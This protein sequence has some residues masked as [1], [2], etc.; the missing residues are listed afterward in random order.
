M[1]RHFYL[2][3][4]ILFLTV[5]C[6]KQQQPDKIKPTR[7]TTEAV[8]HFSQTTDPNYCS[9]DSI[10]PTD[11]GIGEIYLAK[12]GIAF[13]NE[14][15]MG[16]ENTTIIV[17][18]YSITDS[19][20]IC[21]F[22]RYYTYYDCTDCEEQKPVDPNSGKFVQIKPHSVEL[23]KLNCTDYDYCVPQSPQTS[24][25]VF[26]KSDEADT[27]KFTEFISKINS[28]QAL[29]TQDTSQTELDEE[30][31]A[32]NNL[33]F[34]KATTLLNVRNGAGTNYELLFTLSNGSE[35]EFISEDNEWF[36]IKYGDK[37]GFVSSKYLEYS[38]AGRSEKTDS[39]EAESS[40]NNLIVFSIIGIVLFIG[41]IILVLYI[42]DRKKKASEPEV[43]QAKPKV[44]V[45]ATQ[46]QPEKTPEIV[47]VP[48]ITPIINPT[49]KKCPYCAE[50]I[51]WEAIKCKHCSEMLDKDIKTVRQQ[52]ETIKKQTVQPPPPPSSSNVGRVF[53]FGILF[54]ILGL[55]IGYLIF[56]KIPVVGGYI[57][58]EA[59]FGLQNNENIF[60]NIID[61]SFI[62]PIRQNI[63]ICAA[64]SCGIGI[65]IAVLTKKK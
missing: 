21:T 41:L 7:R 14:F 1:K 31:I 51:N 48:E 52:T 63:F 6:D 26:A 60:I 45:E 55:V 23:K 50:E 34:Y 64:V 57:S 20:V 32:L 10:I 43:I 19:N 12:N 40:G 61:N 27:K 38:R 46:T 29:A 24:R 35:V 49:T 39:T 42:I 56:G 44:T 65:L 8:Y 53:L 47:S 25:V 15:C 62:E 59:L 5:A 28:L 33:Y 9:K 22:N 58:L 30:Q 54:T 13:Y 18:I 37:I 36:K 2:A 17:G 11:C 4:I 16:Q 3:T